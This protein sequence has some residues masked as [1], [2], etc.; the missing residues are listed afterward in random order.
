MQAFFEKMKDQVQ[1]FLNDEDGQSTTEYILMLMIVVALA[2]KFKKQI[3]EYLGNATD[4]LG[5][6]IESAAEEAR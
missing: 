1:G 6:N 4:K 2:L 5:K 3:G